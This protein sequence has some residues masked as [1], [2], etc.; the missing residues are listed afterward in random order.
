MGAMW[1]TV[2][3]LLVATL[4]AALGETFLSKGMK[5]IGDVSLHG[6]EFWRGFAAV[7]NPWVLAGIA[8]TT[9]FFVLYCGALSWADMSY[10]Q[11]L[12]ALT[13]V[14]GTL[15]ARYYLGETVS[16]HRWA[17]VAVIVAGVVLVTMDPRQLTVGS[18][19]K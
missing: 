14:F 18:S 13:Y 11:P 15:A 6:A 7:A 12:T 9:V 3:T 19:A 17:G 10:V 2:L 4:S 5:Q 8:C 1:R 16:W